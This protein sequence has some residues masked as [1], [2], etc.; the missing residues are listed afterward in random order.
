ML[1]VV[2]IALDVL[3]C[4]SWRRRRDFE[5][6]EIEGGWCGSRPEAV[7]GEGEDEDADDVTCCEPEG[8]GEKKPCSFP[9]AS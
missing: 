7:R 6:E 5:V 8:E 1:S 9:H 3:E 2:E 4:G